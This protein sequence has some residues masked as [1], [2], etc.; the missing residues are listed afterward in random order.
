MSD[1]EPEGPMG[2]KTT[3]TKSG[4][5]RKTLWIHEDESEALRVRAF[6][7]RCTESSIM[8]EALRRFLGLED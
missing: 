4:M 5:V 6:E 1:R 2:G 8:R 7:D 3:R